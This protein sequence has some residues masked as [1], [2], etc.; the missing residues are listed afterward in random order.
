MTNWSRVQLPVEVRGCLC[1]HNSRTDWKEKQQG[2]NGIGCCLYSNS[3]KF[4]SGHSSFLHSHFMILGSILPHLQSDHVIQVQAAQHTRLL[5][6]AM[7][8]SSWPKP[9]Q[10]EKITELPKLPEKKKS[11]YC[12]RE[13]LKDAGY[14]R[15]LAASWKLRLKL[16]RQNSSLEDTV[17]VLKPAM[18][19][20]KMLSH[21]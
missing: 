12:C 4:S 21:I 6:H 15:H 10:S 13:S 9:V 7:I 3:T 8:G 14:C 17:W 1:M 18:P 16:T 11:M 19:E 5:L 2:K 20:R